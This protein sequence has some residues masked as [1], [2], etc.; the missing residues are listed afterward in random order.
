MSIRKPTR[1]SGFTLLELMI[2]VGIVGLLASVAV[3]SFTRLSLRSRTAERPLMMSSIKRAVVAMFLR[4]GKVEDPATPGELHGADDP[5]TPPG[6]SKLPFDNSLDAGWRRLSQLVQ[7]EGAV[8]YQ[9]SF[10]AV[11]A[12]ANG[13]A[14]LTVTSVGDLDGDLRT[15]ELAVTYE[16]RDGLYWTDEKDATGTW[17]VS[18]TAPNC[19]V[20]SGTF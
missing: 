19:V 4:D 7:F 9:Y 15:S 16:R 12:G 1:P 13:N 17:C 6:T 3:P 14:T 11:E 2:V 18:N 5:A 10:D 20:D 8:Y